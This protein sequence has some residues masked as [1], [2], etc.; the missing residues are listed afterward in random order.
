MIEKQT[1]LFH[2]KLK[3]LGTGSQV[4]RH[5]EQ[6]ELE[7]VVVIEGLDRRTAESIQCT[8]SYMYS[9]GEIVF[10]AGF[11]DCVSRDEEDGSCVVDLDRFGQLEPRTET[12]N[13]AH[14][15]SAT[16]IHA[17][18]G[19][20]YGQLTTCEAGIRADAR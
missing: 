9:R 8:H 18:G 10:D 5:L 16:T 15:T 1:L 17:D 12:M 13:S 7:V 14:A 3:S 2:S 19:L 20:R 11:V 6:S 4:K